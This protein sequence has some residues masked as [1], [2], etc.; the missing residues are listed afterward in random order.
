MSRQPVSISSNLEVVLGPEGKKGRFYFFFRIVSGKSFSLLFSLF[1]E[2]SWFSH[3]H[4]D[5]ENV[6]TRRCEFFLV[7]WDNRVGSVR[8][9]CVC[10]CCG[11]GGGGVRCV[12]VAVREGVA[13]G[14]CVLG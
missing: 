6:K 7:C 8:C 3:F 11:K 10:V 9:V 14:V 13:F 2:K 5:G 4:H 1:F 12:C